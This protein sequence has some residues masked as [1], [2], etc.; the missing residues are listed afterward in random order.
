MSGREGVTWRWD[1]ACAD[2]SNPP[3]QGLHPLPTHPVRASPLV[4]PQL[5]G[6]K[7]EQSPAFLFTP[8]EH[9][10]LLLCPQLWRLPW[11]SREEAE[12]PPSVAG[13]GR[14]CGRLSPGLCV[15]EMVLGLKGWMSVGRGKGCAGNDW[16]GE[17]RSWGSKKGRHVGEGKEG[18]WGAGWDPSTQDRTMVGLH[19]AFARWKSHPFQRKPSSHSLTEKP[20]SP[21]CTGVWPRW[22]RSPHPHGLGDSSYTEVTAGRKHRTHLHKALCFI[23]II[24]ETGWRGLGTSRKKHCFEVADAFYKAIM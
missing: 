1:P 9:P 24:K 7:G 20:S 15:V 2:D 3:T 13:A 5:T 12:L 19:Q 11:Q 18:C 10:L 8:A 6:I 16:G 21:P 17:L 14:D 22:P 23:Y 4:S